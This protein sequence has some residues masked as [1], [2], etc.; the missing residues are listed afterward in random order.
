MSRQD[1]RNVSRYAAP[2]D[3]MPAVMRARWLQIIDTSIATQKHC[4]DLLNDDLQIVKTQYGTDTL[5][6]IRDMQHVQDRAA[7][8]QRSDA[9]NATMHTASVQSIRAAWVFANHLAKQRAQKKLLLIDKISQ[10]CA[11]AA[12][13]EQA[14]A[15]SPEHGAAARRSCRQRPLTVCHA[16][17][18]PNVLPDRF[19]AT[20]STSKKGHATLSP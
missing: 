15:I 3:S 1:L 11:L 20:C 13:R 14:A 9:C 4:D 5:L 10:G 18:A 8:Q 16:S 2:R 6:V 12:M 17:N 7:L 19:A